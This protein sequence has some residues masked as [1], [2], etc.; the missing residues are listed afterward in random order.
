M[1]T[2]P[3]LGFLLGAAYYAGPANVKQAGLAISVSAAN[4]KALEAI[5]PTAIAKPE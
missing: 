4:E 2:S 3:V 5:S 1:D